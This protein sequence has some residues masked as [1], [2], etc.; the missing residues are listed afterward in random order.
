MNVLVLRAVTGEV[1]I[2]F[3]SDKSDASVCIQVEGFHSKPVQPGKLIQEIKAVV[4]E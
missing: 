3:K 4:G 2:D 1:V